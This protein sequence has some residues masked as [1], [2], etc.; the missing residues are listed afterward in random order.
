MVM[1]IPLVL[2]DTIFNAR[3]QLG[4]AVALRRW[5]GKILPDSM[6]R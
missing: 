1:E 4:I 3:Q 5:G 6:I 2:L